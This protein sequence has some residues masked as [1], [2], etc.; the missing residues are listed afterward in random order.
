MDDLKLSERL[1]RIERI[2]FKATKKVLNFDE[3]CDYTGISRSYMYKLTSSRVIPHS[4][5][6]GKIIFFDREKL[7][8]WLLKRPTLTLE[9]I[10]RQAPNYI[11]NNKKKKA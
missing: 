7:D 5:P 3:A 8:E 1:E 2:L 9:D 6:T 4:K 11:L 10:E